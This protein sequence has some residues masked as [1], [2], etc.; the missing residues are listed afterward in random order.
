M[1]QTGKLKPDNEENSVK[2]HKNS[3][4]RGKSG[5]DSIKLT[6]ICKLM[7]LISPKCKLLADE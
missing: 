5:V 7:A 3:Q 2:S 4:K 6:Y 1:N